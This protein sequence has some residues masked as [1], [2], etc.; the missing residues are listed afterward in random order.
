MQ[1]DTFNVYLI[2]PGTISRSAAAPMTFLAMDGPKQW[3][4]VLTQ[5][6]N[7]P[8]ASDAGILTYSEPN[9]E[10]FYCRQCVDYI[11]HVACI[12]F[13]NLHVQVQKVD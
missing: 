8:R 5:H 11:L 6:F 12:N 7:T 3:M 9:P 1:A 10:A 2:I 13:M 4:E